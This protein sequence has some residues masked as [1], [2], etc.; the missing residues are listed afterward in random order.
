MS[1][2]TPPKRRS[3]SLDVQA[4]NLVQLQRLADAGSRRARAELQ[5]RMV[6]ADQAVA[7]TLTA[8]PSHPMPLP[9]RTPA[10]A[11]TSAAV[12]PP[13]TAP[14]PATLAAA[15]QPAADWRASVQAAAQATPAPAFAA[16]PSDELAERLAMLAR[17]D[18]ALTRAS[19][20][21]RLVGLVLL[22]LGGLLVLVSLLVLLGGTRSGLFYLFCGAGL[23]GVGWLLYQMRRLAMPAHGVLLLL[24]MIW[25]WW[26]NNRS[27]T[28]ATMQLLPLLV[29]ALWMLAPAVRDPLD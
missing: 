14:P 8:M 7:P 18:D 27:L 20:P 17:Q 21:P 9:T 22:A 15:P 5:R 23:A 26:S 16:H 29:G 4:L 25:A 2:D 3:S 12:A 13:V 10:P 11:P 1:A 19:G 24:G 28:L 6:A